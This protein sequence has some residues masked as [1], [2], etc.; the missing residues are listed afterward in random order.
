M[1]LA[2]AKSAMSWDLFIYKATLLAVVD[3]QYTLSYCTVLSLFT[4][5]HHAIIVP[6]IKLNAISISS[7]S[8]T[9]YLGD[10]CYCLYMTLIYVLNIITCRS[11]GRV[12]KI[13]CMSC[14]SIGVSRRKCLGRA[15]G[16]HSHSAKYSS[17]GSV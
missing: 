8:H 3:L 1:I 17:P 12:A 2:P 15:K 10:Y 6:I 5:M 7:N 16:G 14:T 13:N 4:C 9:L 11:I